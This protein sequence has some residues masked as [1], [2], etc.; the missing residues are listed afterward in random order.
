MQEVAFV[1]IA[2]STRVD[3]DRWSIIVYPVVKIFH[4]EIAFHE[5]GGPAVQIVRV[6]KNHL[7]EHLSEH[8]LG[9][10]ARESGGFDRRVERQPSS[11]DMIPLVCG[12]APL[13]IIILRV[14]VGASDLEDAG[15]DDLAARVDKQGVGRR[16]LM[17]PASAV[18]AVP[19]CQIAGP[20]R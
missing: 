1:E 15:E 3:P 17:R 6:N 11:F 5:F 19:L 18:M 20:G 10:L 12:V 16:R 7:G 14:V 2:E 13:S 9:I 4:V 8:V